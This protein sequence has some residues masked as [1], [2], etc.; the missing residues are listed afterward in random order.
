MLSKVVLSVECACIKALLLALSIIV[1]F[2]VVIRGILFVAVDASLIA[3]DWVCNY[4]S[5]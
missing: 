4:R 1:D 2:N 5:A 3:A